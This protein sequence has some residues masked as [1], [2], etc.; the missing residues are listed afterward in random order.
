MTDKPVVF[1]DVLVF[2]LA[3]KGKDSHHIHNVQWSQGGM[4]CKEDYYAIPAKAESGSAKGIA[5]FIQKSFFDN[6]LDKFATV[7][8]TANG[9]IARTTI[10]NRFQYGQQEQGGAKRFVVYHD[11]EHKPFQHRFM[12]TATWMAEEANAEKALKKLGMDGN[13][14]VDALK[15]L[16]QNFFGDP[17]RTFEA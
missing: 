6:G 9:K 3:P 7:S 12:T 13:G 16:G 15:L 1:G 2:P 8:E 5:L 11:K 10:D 4:S 14:T 17:L